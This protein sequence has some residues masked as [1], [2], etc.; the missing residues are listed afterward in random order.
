MFIIVR[1]NLLTQIALARPDLNFEYS[2]IT[3]LYKPAICGLY[4]ERQL[5]QWK[6]IKIAAHLEMGLV[7][8]FV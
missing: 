6:F 4:I 7:K 3:S 5:F 8:S 2:E 1:L